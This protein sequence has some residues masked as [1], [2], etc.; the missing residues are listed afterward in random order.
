MRAPDAISHITYTLSPYA[1]YILH[2]IL[3]FLSTM[4]VPL[5]AS[6]RRESFSLSESQDSDKIAELRTTVSQEKEERKQSKAAETIPESAIESTPSTSPAI[7]PRKEK[8]MGSFVNDGGAS[9]KNTTPASHDTPG[10]NPDKRISAVEETPV[11][12][13]PTDPK[14]ESVISGEPLPPPSEPVSKPL[15]NASQGRSPLK[16]ASS[17]GTSSKVSPVKDKLGVKQNGTAGV[18]AHAPTKTAEAKPAGK[19]TSSRPPTAST[20]AS[21]TAKPSGHITTP[22]SPRYFWHSHIVNFTKLT[23]SNQRETNSHIPRIY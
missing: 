2:I 19:P 20:K 11:A 18:K 23:T 8:A 13:R 16:K 6:A 4:K 1:S 12:M 22:K 17:P 7:R 3:T 9:P 15:T 21:A 5:S 14:D 10:A